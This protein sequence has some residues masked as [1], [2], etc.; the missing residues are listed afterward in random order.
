MYDHKQYND[1]PIAVFDSGMGGISVLREM[2]ACMPNEHFLYFGDSLHAPYGTK[3]PEEVR[4]LTIGHIENLMEQGCKAAA[5]ACNTA[6]SAAV[7]K[8][9]EMYPQ[10]PLVGI[11]PALKPAVLAHPGGRV[12][13][14]ATPMTIRLDKFRKLFAEYE[15]QAQIFPLACPGLMEFVEEG[16]T[17][18]ERLLGFL[19]DLLW[20]YADGAVDAA[21][22]GCT[23]YPFVRAQI[24]QV[25]G[26]NTDIF[27]GGAGTA[28]ELK[29]RVEASGLAN[30]PDAEGSVTFENSDPSEEKM[31]LMHRLYTQGGIQ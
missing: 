2:T 20:D 14:M 19:R 15:D 17:D 21:V 25:L 30:R 29:R 22:L 8:L 10:F 24:Q 11:E 5:I 31:Q 16:C 18:R 13:V 28:R 23:H 27:D 3:T 4:T 1:A 9:R 6:T 26:E 12:L 7:R